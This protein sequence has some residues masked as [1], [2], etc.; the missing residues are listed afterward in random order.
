M[1]MN[2]NKKTLLIIAGILIA[3]VVIIL[4]ALV[5]LENKKEKVTMSFSNI[6]QNEKQNPE[7][8]EE[9]NNTVETN[10]TNTVKP[11]KEVTI[12]EVKTTDGGKI[13]VPSNFNY[14]EGDSA[15][16]AVIS[17]ESG[18]EFVW[19]PVEDFNTY[20]RQ[21]FLHNGESGETEI[22]LDDT[23]IRDINSYNDEFDDSIRNYNGFYVARYEAGKGNDNQVISQKDAIV[24]TGVTWENARELSLTM[25]EENDAFQTDLINSYAWDTICNWLRNSGVDI[26]DSTSTGNYQNNVNH[27]DKIVTSGSNENWKTNNIYDMAGNAWEYTT[28]EYGDHEKYHIGRGGGYWNEGHVYPISCRGQSEDNANL[29][30]GFRVVM[31]LK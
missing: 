23:N 12:S 19:V 7:N 8:E 21:M 28:E 13:P 17:D 9:E 14:I 31:Y 26:D 27:Q 29:A 22:S 15:S 10:T 16:G 6:V 1:N 18:N 25:Y 3:L 20:E 2:M 30:I 24:W 11:E 5:I 4:I